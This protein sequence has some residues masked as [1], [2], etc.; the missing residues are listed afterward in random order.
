MSL[1]PACYYVSVLTEA[2]EFVGLGHEMLGKQFDGVL[3]CLPQ[4]TGVAAMLDTRE[5]IRQH[6]VHLC[7]LEV[8]VADL[9][10][11]K[12]LISLL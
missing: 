1:N 12:F 11:P 2:L 8:Q 9:A 10:E 5:Q 4:T 3:S 7:E 6:P